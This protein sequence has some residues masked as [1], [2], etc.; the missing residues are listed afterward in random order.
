MSDQP[1]VPVETRAERAL[2][3]SFAA[4]AALAWPAGLAAA[5]ARAEHWWT[6][7]ENTFSVLTSWVIALACLGLGVAVMRNEDPRAVQ[8]LGFL[9]FGNPALDEVLCPARIPWRSRLGVRVSFGV[10][11]GACWLVSS[12]YS[13]QVAIG[14]YRVPTLTELFI[15]IWFLAGAIWST[16]I[17]VTAPAE[18]RR[19]AALKLACDAHQAQR[20]KRERLHRTA[21]SDVTATGEIPRVRLG[22]LI[23]YETERTRRGHY[24]ASG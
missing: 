4:L 13:V 17:V 22:D 24:G 1:P 11:A 8:A 23:D 21:T 5:I 3:H 19:A 6:P 14:V 16:V 2:I 7:A 10:A 20:A 18:C 12:I 15:L 9:D